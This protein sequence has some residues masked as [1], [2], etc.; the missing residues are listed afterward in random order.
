MIRSIRLKSGSALGQPPITIQEPMITVFVGPNNS[1][2]S[3]VLREIHKFCHEGSSAGNL[4]LDEVVFEALSEDGYNQHL[5]ESLSPPR[6]G[7][8]Q[9]E[10]LMCIE[11][12]YNRLQVVKPRYK[13]AR[14]NPN[15]SADT[16]RDYSLWCSKYALINLDGANRMR[17]VDPQSRGDLV[18]PKTP[19]ARILTN[20]EIR[21]QIRSI[22]FD[23]F[24]LY[25]GI[26]MSKGD[27]LHVNF[28]DT[29][30]PRERTVEADMLEWT[31]NAKG[32]ENVSD[33]VKAF[34]GMLLQLYVGNP[35]II[36]IDEPEAFLHP[37]LAF[38]L[39]QELS[40][41]AV[42]QGKHVFVSTHNSQFL[43]GVV[44]SGA[45]VNIVRLTYEGGVAT[46]RTL[47][48]EN[49]SSMMNDP[50]LRSA[51][52]MSG[53]FYKH[54]V[55][56]EA[57][58]DRAFYQEVN[59][60]LKDSDIRRG[61]S[62]TL[63]VNAN[64]KDTVHRI[65]APLRRLGIPCAAIVD[66]DV[67]NQGGTSWTNHLSA[68]SIP[69]TQHQPLGTMRANTWNALI[70]GNK[71]PKTDG[72]ISLLKGDGKEAAENLLNQLKD[73]GF[74]IVSVGEVER[75]FAELDID[76]GKHAWLRSIFERM[77]NDPN[78]P[79]YIRPTDEDV[80]AF[81]DEIRNWLNNPNRRGIPTP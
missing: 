1:G 50:F 39:G 52:V 78:A 19:F 74:F 27:Q 57:D 47:S 15:R 65:I 6:D 30:P 63:F 32:I 33:G 4:V 38:K 44:Q 10:H 26:D 48:E 77:G 13:A 16:L 23:A 76:R 81:I 61:C 14:L 62:N 73:Y 64:G 79:N 11:L 22:I 24:G 43:M 75:W 25:L 29:P 21:E 9:G 45:R 80:W 35:K 8:N 55:V 7:D 17:L 69:E 59:D 40:K 49:L 18:N 51:N 2:K 66:I 31:R 53:L 12:E 58:A 42:Q 60:R 28:G 41:L 68:L 72:G 37:S 70:Q 56:T 5:R 71:N 36:I 34:T 3:Q 46:A 67:L 20:D 54:V